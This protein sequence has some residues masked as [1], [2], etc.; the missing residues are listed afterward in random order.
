MLGIH[1]AKPQRPLFSKT[2]I[3][4]QNYQWK[5]CFLEK[6]ILMVAGHSLEF[7]QPEASVDSRRYFSGRLFRPL[8]CFL[9]F[10]FFFLV[11]TF[12]MNFLLIRTPPQ[13]QTEKK[14]WWIKFLWLFPIFATCF[15]VC[16]HTE[17]LHSSALTSWYLSV[18]GCHILKVVTLSKRLKGLASWYYLCLLDWKMQQHLKWVMFIKVI[19]PYRHTSS[20]G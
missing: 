1:T 11:F 16:F 18:T 17:T 5:E 12:L 2:P 6:F 20:K 15:T 4:I 9:F 14:E 10:S 13:N 3:V 19:L 7:Y 8:T